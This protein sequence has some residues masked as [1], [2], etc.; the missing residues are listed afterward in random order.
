MKVTEKKIK[1]I[2]EKIYKDLDKLYAIYEIYGKHLRSKREP[3]F[4]VSPVFMAQTRILNA[5]RAIGEVIG[6]IY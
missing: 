2:S 3:P 6:N 5:K 4:R 1:A